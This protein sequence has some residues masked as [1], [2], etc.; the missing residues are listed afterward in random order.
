[1]VKASDGIMW[2][3][4]WINSKKVNRISS[5]TYLFYNLAFL[6]H[7]LEDIKNIHF[8]AIGGSV[9]HNL[10]IALQQSGFHVTGSDDMIF[11]PAKTVLKSHNLLPEIGWNENNIKE[12]TD[13][14]ILGMHAKGDNPELTRAKALGKSVLSF[15]QFIRKLSDHKQRV[16]IGG[17]HGKST[18]TAMI[19]HVLKYWRR[20]F[21]FVAGAKMEGFSLTV[22]LSDAPLI[23]I[24]GDE[25]PDSSVNKIPKF[26]IYDHHIGLISGI[27][28][29]HV[30]MF[31]TLE[32][33]VKQFEVF[34]DKT[35]KAGTLI[36]SEDDNMA[37]LVGGKDRPDV[38]NIPY[39]AHPAKIENEQTILL[40]AKQEIPVKI[41]GS[42]NLQNISA[43]KAILKRLGITETQFYEAIRS[44]KGASRR[45]ELLAENPHTKVYED[46]AHSPSKVAATAE[47]FKSQYINKKLVACFE[48]HT[49]SSLNKDFLKQ[50]KGTFNTPDIAIVYFNPKN[51]KAKN[52]EKFGVEE[53]KAGFGR[54]DLHVFNNIDEL[55]TSLMKMNWENKILLMM[56][57]GDFDGLNLK[58]FAKAIVNK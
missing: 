11:D 6:R 48:L 53:I 37:S 42:H 20:A 33:Y 7:M 46:Y 13:L 9:M 8:I 26:H 43:A 29:D 3:Y 1:M 40:T 45:M 35:P 54:K 58:K 25:Y 4:L 55:Q 16:V 38:S 56:S 2:I 28:W 44:F 19:V 47:A 52:L 24:E 49:F 27:A 34:A 17:S 22:K 39:K 15:P 30:N 10:A 57:S 36:Y 51:F 23:V 14:V 12:D 50:Y 32:N 41:F 5:L 31:P 18:I 21:D